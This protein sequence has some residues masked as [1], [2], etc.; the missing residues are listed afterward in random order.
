M[1]DAETI[2]NELQLLRIKNT[3]RMMKT[4]SYWS[5]NMAMRN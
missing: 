3:F 4:K 2:A 5:L 1:Y